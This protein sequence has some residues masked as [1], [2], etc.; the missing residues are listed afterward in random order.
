[1]LLS[2]AITPALADTERPL[3]EVVSLTRVSD[4][5][6]GSGGM[7]HS[8]GR[9]R[10]PHDTLAE[11]IGIAFEVLPEQISGLPST[12]AAARYDIVL[13]A[14]ESS[15][16]GAFHGEARAQEMLRQV[17][18]D[19]FRLAFHRES[20]PLLASALV[21][22]PAG[23]KMS[24][25]PAGADDWQGIDLDTHYLVGRQVPM[26]RLAKIV[27]LSTGRPVLDRTGLAATY[28]FSAQ[29]RADDNLSHHRWYY[30]GAQAPALVAVTRASSP[31]FEEALL[32]QLGLS[33]EPAASIVV[34]FIVV[35]S[36]EEP[37]D[38]PTAATTGRSS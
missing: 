24:E 3:F 33:L 8:P 16:V 21:V 38:A 31:S 28:D 1:M 12:A 20:R 17:L 25:S 11:L 5:D 35:D 37:Q 26:I 14:P 6:H 29:W 34:E 22:G 30:A 19:Q 10:F 13:A 2:L 7:Q 15:F 32:D 23:V 27:S 36:N 9:V 18:A 4:S